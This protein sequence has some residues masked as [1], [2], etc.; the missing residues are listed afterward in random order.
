[1]LFLSSINNQQQEG[2]REFENGLQIEL[3]EA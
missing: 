3:S 1:M 2:A